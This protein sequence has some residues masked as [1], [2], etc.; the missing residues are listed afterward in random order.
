MQNRNITDNLMRKIY[1]DFQLGD[2]FYATFQN[3]CLFYGFL[4]NNNDMIIRLSQ[5]ENGIFLVGLSLFGEVITTP[6]I[7]NFNQNIKSKE[8]YNKLSK[9]IYINNFDIFDNCKNY[10][11]FIISV[12][13]HGW[14]ITYFT[15]D[16]NIINN[17]S[18]NINFESDTFYQK[19]I[20]NLIIFES[21]NRNDIY[22]REILDKSDFDLTKNKELT[23][24]IKNISKL[25]YNNY[26]NKKYTAS[27]NSSTS[28]SNLNLI[29]EVYPITYFFNGIEIEK[30]YISC[31]INNITDNSKSYINNILYSIIDRSAIL[32]QHNID[33]DI[34]QSL[35][36]KFEGEID[37]ILCLEVMKRLEI[38]NKEFQ[39]H[40]NLNS[41]AESRKLIIFKE[42]LNFTQY[43]N[44]IENM[45][46][47]VVAV[48]TVKRIGHV[49]K[50]NFIG[51]SE[52][53]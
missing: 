51:Q 13:E 10:D 53:L 28:T 3:K 7:I 35:E 42:N 16:D 24:I 52:I 34:M 31:D 39:E 46:T 43:K 40:L 4:C 29:H 2:F 18:K 6:K 26:Y 17:N 22:S 36:R 9:N 25:K 12:A 49:E 50:S 47:P 33:F 14:N 37:K 8:Y 23:N 44:M 15:K 45:G 48:K 5:G 30:I 1:S 41:Y 27:T 38:S 19:K 21:N 20:F 32:G 11:Q